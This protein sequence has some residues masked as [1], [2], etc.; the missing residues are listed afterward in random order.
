MNVLAVTLAIYASG[1]LSGGHLNPAVTLALAVRGE[2]PWPRLVPYWGAQMAGALVGALL[3]YAD[4]SSAFAAFEKA[5]A[6]HRGAL[7]DGKLAGPHAGG[8]GVFATP[9]RIEFDNLV[10]G[11]SAGSMTSC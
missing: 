2:V 11:M 6:I 1:R 5:S 3:V 7:L 4:Y 9:S 10:S 8:A